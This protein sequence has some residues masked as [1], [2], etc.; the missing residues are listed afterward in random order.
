MKKNFA[1]TRYSP[2]IAREESHE[3]GT[4][5]QFKDRLL[6]RMEELSLE[7]HKKAFRMPV[8]LF[9]VVGQKS[10]GDSTA[11]EIA[12]RFKLID[13]ES[14]NVIDFYFLGW[15]KD[16]SGTIKFDEEDFTECR[17]FLEANEIKKF[18]GNADLILV[19]AVRHEDGSVIL[20]FPEAIRIDL[21]AS[22]AEKGFLTLGSFL[23]SIIETAKAV[24]SDV[25]GATA[26]GIVFEMSDK[27]GI[28]I[29]KNS[30]LN[31]IL[32][33]FGKIIGAKKLKDLAVK[34]LGQPLEI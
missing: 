27:L 8:G 15:S 1:G 14:Q 18:G 29:T 6:K 23:E 21:S 31:F 20:D 5:S 25:P 28:A 24:K 26:T 4:V 7:F 2:L 13:L 17:R 10:G 30:I 11:Q 22:K 3:V 33:K 12:K 34:D 9:L 32:E 19:D 16:P